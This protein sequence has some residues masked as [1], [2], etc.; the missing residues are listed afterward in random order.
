[1]AEILC[2]G[3]ENIWENLDMRN[4]WITIGAGLFAAILSGCGPIL[5]GAG[6][7]VIADKAVEDER[8]GDGLF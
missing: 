5:V 3:Q 6:G 1:M 7:A 2:Y 8:G 4:I